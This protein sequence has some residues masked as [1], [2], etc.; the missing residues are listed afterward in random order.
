MDLTILFDAIEATFTRRGYVV[1]SD[2]PDGLT[3]EFASETSRQRLWEVLLKKNAMENLA[4][5]DVVKSIRHAL[6]PAVF[7]KFII[8]G[9]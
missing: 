4:L 9:Q 7:G 8:S 3:D 5:I 6:Y 2:I 1:N